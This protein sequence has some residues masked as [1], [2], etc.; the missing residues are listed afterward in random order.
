VSLFISNPETGPVR[1]GARGRMIAS[2]AP[3]RLAL[4]TEYRPYWMVRM[5]GRLQTAWA[6]RF[7]EP[8]FAACGP[9]LDAVFPWFVEVYG[10][11]IRIGRCA[12]LR[13]SRGHRLSLTTWTS[14]DR[15]GRI[16]IGDYVLISP[17][18][19]ILSSD[20]ITIGSNTM[21]AGEVYISDS[22]WHDIYDRT[23][24]RSQHRPIVLEENVWIGFRAIIGKGVRIGENSII[25]AGSVVTRDIPANVIAAGNPARPVRDLSPDGDF[26]RRCDLYA[27]PEALRA[28][29][30]RLQRYL[31]RDNS[32]FTW[33]WHRWAPGRQD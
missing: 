25:G 12:T 1:S 29:M 23:S 31:L 16:D 22:D 28:E 13:T 30:D 11:N 2:L 7:L 20:S 3:G 8:R 10:P 18:T 9:H 5:H 24:E 21:I 19:R 14:A 26:V 15:E 17:G 27:D 6:R 4:K 33:L 32:I